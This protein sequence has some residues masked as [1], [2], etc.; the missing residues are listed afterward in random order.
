MQYRLFILLLILAGSMASYTQEIEI[1]GEFRPRTEYTHGLKTLAAENQDPGFHTTQRTRLNAGYKGNWAEAYLS[2][3]DVRT[4]GNQR[5]LVGNED[6]ALSIHQAWAKAYIGKARKAAIK[7]GRQEIIYDDSRFFGNVGWAQQARSHDALL[8]QFTP[9]TVSKLDIGLAFNQNAPIL[10][11]TVYTVPG[12]Y[13]T[14]QFA[15]F[16]TKLNDELGLSLLAL[17]NGV[18]VS[19]G[20]PTEFDTKFSQTFGTHLNYKK[21]KL[22]LT[23]NAYLQTGKAPVYTKT[24]LSAYLLGFDL[25]YKLSDIVTGIIG[26]ELQSGNSQTDQD[27]KQKAFTPLYGTNH[28]FN[29]H[30]DYFYVGNHGGSVG[31][32]DIYAKAKF[33]LPK[34]GLGA[35]LHFFSAAADVR[36]PATTNDAM[37]AYLGTELDLSSKFK[38]NPMVN[39]GIGYSHMFPS[40]TMEVLKGGSKDATQNWIY[41]MVSFNPKFIKSLKE[42]N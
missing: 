36:D 31:L 23:A 8:L 10:N 25:S 13:K 38:L 42:T 12:N 2:A 33:K 29:G 40:E 11:S 22:G 24:D 3:Q 28:K 41:A 7:A 30:M 15:W 6:N 17:N 1:S 18:Q 21:D 19:G 39:A 35:D 34:V 26:G 4:W 32:A 37:P 14:I 5:Q 27:A 20:I 9:G 16:N